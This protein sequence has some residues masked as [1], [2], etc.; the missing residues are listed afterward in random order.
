MLI[1]LLEKKRFVIYFVINNIKFV[2]YDK[3]EMKTLCN[4]I[5]T[6]VVKNCVGGRRK[7]KH[8]LVIDDV[9][10]STQ[11]LKNNKSD[12][13][14]KTFSCNLLNASRMSIILLSLLLQCI[15]THGIIPEHMGLGTITPIIIN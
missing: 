10:Q 6:N 14:H 4:I 12:G 2:R 11:K 15:L 1:I 5:D 8:T 9:C 7:N 13:N 3:E